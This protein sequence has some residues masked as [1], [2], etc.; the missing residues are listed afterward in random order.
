M[1]FFELLNTVRVEDQCRST[2]QPSNDQGPKVHVTK[3][4]SN[5]QIS[6]FKPKG[7][8]FKKKKMG[9]GQG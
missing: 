9:Q 3:V 1:S 7:K 5:P 2:L 8:K 4:F 6:K